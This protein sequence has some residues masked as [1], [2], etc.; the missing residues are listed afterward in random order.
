MTSLLSEAEARERANVHVRCDYCF[1]GTNRYGEDCGHCAVERASLAAL[2]L[3]VQREGVEA[4]AE[5][6]ERFHDFGSEK[7]KWKPSLNLNDG[8]DQ[9]RWYA[10][11]VRALLP[12][13]GEEG[14][15]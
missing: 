7:Y 4:A 12:V 3:Q 1:A 8:R 15:K 6:L 5:R 9:M 14:G 11:A 13:Q 10:N 2:L